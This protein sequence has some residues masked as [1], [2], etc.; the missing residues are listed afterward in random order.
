MI[1]T[2]MMKHITWEDENTSIVQV[3]FFMDSASDLPDDLYYFSTDTDRY[4]TAQGSMGY[5]ISTG[6]MYISQSDGTW[7]NQAQ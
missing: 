6:D 5:D 1:D 3:F 4:K 7:V 2:K